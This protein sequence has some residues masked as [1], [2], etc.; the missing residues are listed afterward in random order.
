MKNKKLKKIIL[1]FLIFL[2]SNNLIVPV[3]FFLASEDSSESLSK[4]TS[5]EIE[6]KNSEIQKKNEQIEAEKKIQ[7]DQ[8]KSTQKEIDENKKKLFELEESMSKN[9]EEIDKLNKELPKLE[10][11]AKKMLIALQK[12]ENTNVALKLL[13][14]FLESE[15]SLKDYSTNSK[16]FDILIQKTNNKLT[17]TLLKKEELEHKKEELKKQ[18]TDAQDIQEKLKKQ[19]EKIKSSSLEEIQSSATSAQKA[20]E[21]FFREAG[22]SGDDVYGRDCKKDEIK[23]QHEFSRPVEKG[24]VTNEFQE[25]DIYDQADGHTGIDIAGGEQKVYPTATGQVIDVFTDSYGG[26]QILMIHYVNGKN[27]I[28]NYAHL[29]SVNVVPGQ[30]V[31]VKDEIGVTGDTGTATGVHLHFEL[32]EGPYYIHGELEN[33]RIYVDF[34]QKYSPFTSR[35]LKEEEEDENEKQ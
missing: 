31:D 15:S 10:D 5:E 12:V 7:S 13:S 19:L 23:E 35:L 17:E 2:S 33:P 8:I 25:F 28:S 3:Q 4:E 14:N 32:I 30:K 24:Y 20:T 16:N 9:Q 6:S 34:P 26:T 27:Y 22:C 21:S 18:K 1:I 29:S 11:S